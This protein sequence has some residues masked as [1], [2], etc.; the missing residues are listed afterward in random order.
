ML[1]LSSMQGILRT[2]KFDINVVD[3]LIKVGDK[4]IRGCLAQNP[5]ITPEQWRS[6]LF[7][8][9]IGVSDMARLNQV[10]KVTENEDIVLKRI[11]DV[12]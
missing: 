5:N 1:A 7:D 10:Y 8:K 12:R 4:E 9:D 6:L 3:K 11:A 2:E